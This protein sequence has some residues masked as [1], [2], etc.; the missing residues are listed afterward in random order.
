MNLPSDDESRVN[1]RVTSAGRLQRVW[2]NRSIQITDVAVIIVAING[3]LRSESKVKKLR[4]LH[5]WSRNSVAKFTR[6]NFSGG[7]N[8]N[9]GGK[10]AEYA[11]YACFSDWFTESDA[12]A[13]SARQQSE[14]KFAQTD[15]SEHFLA[16]L[17][18]LQTSR[19]DPIGSG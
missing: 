14:T 13:Q 15:W 12:D 8:I 2:C 19:S 4:D 7:V 11:Y 1:V 18:L 3:N 17:V 5:W 9:T 10:C 6:E 16:F